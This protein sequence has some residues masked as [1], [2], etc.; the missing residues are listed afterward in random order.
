MQY[1]AMLA[2]SLAWEGPQVFDCVYVTGL[3]VSMEG[4]CDCVPHVESVW[5][6]VVVGGVRLI[7]QARHPSS[8]VAAARKQVN[9]P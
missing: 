9:W 5:M 4:H 7:G 8:M 3:I 1:Q 6:V 2:L